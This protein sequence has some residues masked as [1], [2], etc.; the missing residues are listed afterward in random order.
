MA[1]T[2]GKMPKFKVQKN[3]PMPPRKTLTSRL[4]EFFYDMDVGDSFLCDD[5]HLGSIRKSVEGTEMEIITHYDLG[6]YRV[7]RSK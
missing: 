2:V 1:N 7:W 6:R 3:I 4:R 5:T